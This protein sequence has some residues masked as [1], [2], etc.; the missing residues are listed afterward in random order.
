MNMLAERQLGRLASGLRGQIRKDMRLTTARQL[1]GVLTVLGVALVFGLTFGVEWQTVGATFALYVV[2]VS[3]NELI[4]GY[5]GSPSFGQAGSI[6]IGAYTYAI[7]TARYDWPVPAGLVLATAVA[8]VVG[9]CIWS[10]M[11]NLSEIYFAVA[12]L[13]FGLVVPAVAIALESVTGGA[14]GIF[15]IKPITVGGEWLPIEQFYRLSWVLAALATFVTV[16]YATSR[17]GLGLRIIRADSDLAAAL[18]VNTSA[19]RRGAYVYGCALAGLVGALLAS[20]YQV[21]T[22][23]SFL[24]GL[25]VALLAVQVVGGLGSGY[26]ALV[27]GLLVGI[28]SMYTVGYGEYT[29]LVYGGLLLLV[30]ALAPLG[31]V[32]VIQR[33]VARVVR[34][35]SSR[36]STPDAV[37][38]LHPEKVFTSPMPVDLQ[39]QGVSKS[40]GGVVA[41][42][43][44]SLALQSGSITGIVGANGAGKSTMINIICGA[45]TADSGEVRL[46]GIA[47][48]HLPVHKRASLGIGRTFQQPKLLETT[49]VLD[50][51]AAGAYRHGR[52]GLLSG[53]FGRRGHLEFEEGRSRARDALA[54]VGA[55]PLAGIAASDLSFGQLRLMELA[56]ALVSEPRLLLLDEPM[57]GLDTEERSLISDVLKRLAEDGYAIALVEH[58]THAVANLCSHVYVLEFG[59]IIAEGPGHSIFSQAVVKRSYLGE[60]VAS[61]EEVPS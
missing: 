17:S 22:P 50:N 40:F 33:N 26:G 42:A 37:G 41:S 28:M 31:L 13:G 25:L 1:T 12:T 59:A 11:S 43:D 21:I 39:V 23:S 46:D 5:G 18:G 48:T 60:A 38:D 16:R 32:G 10:F 44:V 8:A 6:A 4:W 29:G 49:S 55:A 14:A 34:R 35:F 57:S 27:G 19:L 7:A 30:L 53:L 47:L 36:R 2:A 20:L 9:L 56:R 24:F 54:L 58:D 3:G 45:V 61:A 51:V 52:S 15:A